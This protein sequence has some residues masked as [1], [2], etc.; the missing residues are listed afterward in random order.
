LEMARLI[1]GVAELDGV[2][3]GDDSEM[4]IGEESIGMNTRAR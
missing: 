3:C 4:S 2:D 1:F